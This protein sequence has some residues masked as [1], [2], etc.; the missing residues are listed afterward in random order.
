M[1]YT[2][3]ARVM[4]YVNY[5]LISKTIYCNYTFLTDCL[6]YASSMRAQYGLIP[7]PFCLDSCSPRRKIFSSPFKAT[8]TILESI[9]VNR[10][11]S[12]LMQ[13]K[14]TKYLQSNLKKSGER[15]NIEKDLNIVYSNDM[16]ILFSEMLYK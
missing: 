1:L 12:G 7:I 11:Q 6:P 8:W 3:E 4:L 16:K 5:T 10:S 14:A 15:N 13:P 2:P 9:T